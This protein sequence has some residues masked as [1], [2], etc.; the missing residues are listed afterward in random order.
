ML[1]VLLLAHN[2]VATL[3]AEQFAGLASLRLLD[4][5]HNRLRAVPADALAGTSLERLDLSHNA[6]A[7]V[8]AAALARLAEGG[9]AS[10]ADGPLRWLGLAGNAIHHLDGTVFLAAAGLQHLDLSDNRLA[11]VPDNVFS[12]LGAL[13]SLRLGRNPLRGTGGANLAELFHYTHGLRE[14]G[15]DAVGLHA[16]PSLPLPSLVALNLSGNALSTAPPGG[17]PALR[18]LQL[19]GNRLTAGPDQP[20]PLL[21]TLDLSQNPITELGRESF[22]EVPR[23]R[24]LTLRGLPLRALAA[25]ALQPLRQLRELRAEAWPD[26]AALGRALAAAPALRVLAL[27]VGAEAAGDPLP[28]HV[29]AGA[30]RP[31]LRRLELSGPGLRS[32][33]GDSLGGELPDLRRFTLQVRVAAQ[34]V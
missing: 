2:H 30:L 17:L 33:S 27:A 20:L 32:L 15:L 8:P 16:L 34:T 9:R 3:Q 24:S 31:G 7:V 29:L 23:L 21:S 6:L 28:L 18:E 11:F 25:D 14:L 13:L 22:A 5:S 26:V 19:A 10:R 12:P 4:L 1:Q